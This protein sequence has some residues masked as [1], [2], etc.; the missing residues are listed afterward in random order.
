M[1][2]GPMT[3]EKSK[4]QEI[5]PTFLDLCEGAHD[6]SLIDASSLRP[7]EFLAQLAHAAAHELKQTLLFN[8]LNVVTV[9]SLTAG[10]IAKTLVD[11][12]QPTSSVVYGGFVVYDT[13]AKRTWCNVSTEGVYSVKTAKQMAEGALNNSRAMVAIAVTGQAMPLFGHESE[14]GKVDIAVSFRTTPKF[15]TFG[16][17]LDLDKDAQC[18]GIIDAWK[19]QI[20]SRKDTAAPGKRVFAD[21]WLTSMAA[22]AVRLRTTV[23][24]LNFA[25]HLLKVRGKIDPNSPPDEVLYG[26]DIPPTPLK[27]AKL[28]ERAWDRTSERN[29]IIKENMDAIESEN[30]P[31]DTKVERDIPME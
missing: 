1:E 23:L 15:E 26:F 6:K 18:K 3:P 12:P 17:P 10:M 4:I 20:Q 31:S 25:N 16:K 7:I 11:L 19:S 21:L 22:D 8:N 24:A 27:F 14:M 13:D 28:P 2:L 30:L 5:F 29:W 9:E